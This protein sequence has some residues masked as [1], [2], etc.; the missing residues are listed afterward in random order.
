MKSKFKAISIVMIALIISLPIC[1]ASEL[2]LIYDANGNLVSGDG[3]YREYDTFNQL[4]R[5]Y[6]GSNSSGVLLENYQYDP[7]EE[8]VAIKTLYNSDSSVKETIYYFDR[9][10]VRVVNST[11]TYNYEYV[12]LEGQ[13]VGQVNPDSTKYFIHGDH[14]GSIV[15]VSNEASQILENNSY[16]PFGTPKTS[17]QLRYGYEGKAFS[18]VLG[19][20]DFNFRHMGIAGVPIFQ[21][22]D[23]IMEVYDPQSLNRY[24]FEKNNPYKHKDDTGHF[25]VLIAAAALIGGIYN[26]VQYYRTHDNPTLGGAATYFTTGAVQGGLF[27]AN[28]AFV[29]GAALL[30]EV[31]ERAVDGRSLTEDSSDYLIKGALAFGVAKLGE[32]L[33]PIPKGAKNIKSFTSLFTKKSGKQFILNQLGAQV[34]YSNGYGAYTDARNN[35]G[36]AGNACYMY[37]SLNLQAPIGGIVSNQNSNT[38]GQTGSYITST[39]GLSTAPTMPLSWF[40]S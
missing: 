25:P 2:N 29:V 10:H 28:A 15:A 18:S 36:M 24:S 16:D 37:S 8:R 21:Q 30:S 19:D 11:G 17:S 22:P 5:I 38:P 1:F 6:N 3:F 12:Y 40:R 27:A 4:S 14:K 7:I 20:T 32:F 31:A 33:T 26:T 39:G 34:A 9:E 35:N 23:T 13:L